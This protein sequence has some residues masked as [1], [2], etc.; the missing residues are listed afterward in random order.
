MKKSKF[1]EEGERN[2]KK[3]A[4]LRREKGIKKKNKFE[5]EG[6]RNFKKSKLEEE[7]ER[8]LKNH[9][10]EAVESM[11]RI[12]S[13]NPLFQLHVTIQSLHPVH[14]REAW[15]SSM[16][17]PYRLPFLTYTVGLRQKSKYN[18][19]PKSALSVSHPPHSHYE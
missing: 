11:S 13:G 17:P 15:Y 3:K 6:E 4:N 2:L 10:F 14:R 5:E 9:K 12:E 7:G 18:R 1:M 8:N 16:P 19:K